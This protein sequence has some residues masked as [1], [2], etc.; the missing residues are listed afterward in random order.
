MLLQAVP[1]TGYD[2]DR[3]EGDVGSIDNELMANTYIIAD[4]DYMVT[5][6]FIAMVPAIPGLPFAALIASLLIGAG[7]L[8][9]RRI[10]VPPPS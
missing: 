7:F 8:V 5:A 2:F 6:V 3:W 1:A 4:G 10:G 9:L